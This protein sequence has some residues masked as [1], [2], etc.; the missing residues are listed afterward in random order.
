MR[1]LSSTEVAF[2]V[3]IAPKTLEVWYR[4]KRENPDNEYALMLP[5]Y[6]QDGA[7]KP[8]YWKEEDIEKILAFKDAIPHGRNG[9][10]GNITHQNTYKKEWRKRKNGKKED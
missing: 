1:L 10:F 4:F 5:A 6:K 3:G 9:L 8:R 2:L 7:N